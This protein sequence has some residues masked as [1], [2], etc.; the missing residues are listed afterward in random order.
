MMGRL[1][2]NCKFI[3]ISKLTVVGKHFN[4]ILADSEIKKQKTHKVNKISPSNS[5][6]PKD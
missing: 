6:Q 3:T 5:L 4:I 1:H 2:E